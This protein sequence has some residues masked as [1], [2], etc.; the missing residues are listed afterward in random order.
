MP[1]C[2]SLYEIR[3]AIDRREQMITIIE[4]LRGKAQK[5]RRLIRD[6]TTEI[7]DAYPLILLPTTPRTAFGLGTMVDDP[8]SLYLEDIFTILGNLAGVPAISLPL[9]HH[10]N[11]MPFGVQLMSGSFRE[12]ELLNFSKYMLDNFNTLA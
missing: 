5:A 8:V 4:G 7:L 3:D 12:N 6:K 9:G 2:R 1:P 11:G 10:S